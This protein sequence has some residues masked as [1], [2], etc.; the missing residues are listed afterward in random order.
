MR[1]SV[2][3]AVL[4]SAASTLHAMTGEELAIQADARIRGFYD[5]SVSLRMELISPAGGVRNGC[6]GYRAWST[7]RARKP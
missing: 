2:I 5:Q 6:Y 3:S 4:L 7:P 1:M